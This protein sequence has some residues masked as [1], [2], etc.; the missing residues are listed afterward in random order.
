M[1]P[2]PLQRPRWSRLRERANGGLAAIPGAALLP[3][4]AS[5]C[6][7]DVGRHPTHCGH[8]RPPSRLGAG[9]AK[10][11]LKRAFQSRLGRSMRRPSTPDGLWRPSESTYNRTRGRFSPDRRS[12][13]RM[14]AFDMQSGGSSLSDCMMEFQSLLHIRRQSTSSALSHSDEQRH[15]KRPSRRSRTNFRRLR[16]MKGDDI[17]FTPEHP[18]ASV[19]H[20]M[21]GAVRS[22]L[23]AIPSK[24]R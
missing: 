7:V 2:K 5:V 14:I 21:R 3:T 18:E 23:K 13:S 22:G 12:R 9:W 1:R 15:V 8:M 20:I 24:N 19:R 11:T 16:S 17:L 6:S 4:W 10:R